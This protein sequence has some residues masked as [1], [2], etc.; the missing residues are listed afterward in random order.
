MNGYS[1]CCY[2]KKYSYCKYLKKGSICVNEEI[3]EKEVKNK[4]SN[5]EF[6]NEEVGN[7]D[8]NLSDIGNDGRMDIVFK[9]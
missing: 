4:G 5:K 1:K 8:I 9:N 6:L 3:I 7:V 2:C